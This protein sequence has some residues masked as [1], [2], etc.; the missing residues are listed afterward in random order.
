[1]LVIF[2]SPK[3]NVTW[4]LGG[5]DFQIDVQMPT[6]FAAAGIG[7]VKPAADANAIAIA[8]AKTDRLG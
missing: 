8:I 1:L 2:V 5:N 4:K 7:I 6:R 3:H